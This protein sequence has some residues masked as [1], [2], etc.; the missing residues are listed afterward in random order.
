MSR[1]FERITEDELRKKIETAWGKKDTEWGNDFSVWRELTKQIEKDIKVKFDCENLEEEGLRTLDNGFT[2]YLLGAGGDWE[3]PVN[4]IIYWDGKKLRGYVPTDGNLYNTSAMRAY[5]NNGEEDYQE[6]PGAELDRINSHKRFGTDIDDDDFWQD[7]RFQHDHVAMQEEMRE[8]IKE[9][10][11]VN[12]KANKVRP[13]PVPQPSLERV[14]DTKN[15]VNKVEVKSAEVKKVKLKTLII[16]AGYAEN[17]RNACLIIR[18]SIGFSSVE[19]AM[20]C[21]ANDV[22]SA[23][24]RIRDYESNDCCKSHRDKKYCA[25]CGKKIDINKDVT[26]DK[27]KSL[28]FS[29]FDGDADS[30]WWDSYGEEIGRWEI[31]AYGIALFQEEMAIIHRSGERVFVNA[32]RKLISPHNFETETEIECWVSHTDIKIYKDV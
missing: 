4:F 19:E 31:G 9:K 27:L 2:Y 20:E 13:K 6:D 5:G 26:T 10:G 17:S 21:F 22:V 3:S 32:Y 16:N 1:Y 29:I 7:F 25:D 15:Y 18:H 23:D 8:R 24:Q 28:F 30:N 12:I 14:G 11:V